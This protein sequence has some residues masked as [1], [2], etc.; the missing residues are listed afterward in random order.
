MRQET[1]SRLFAAIVL[2]FVT[3]TLY[4]TGIDMYAA[5]GV[6]MPDPPVVIVSIF[7]YIGLGLELWKPKTEWKLQRKMLPLAIISIFFAIWTVFTFNILTGRFP[8]GLQNPLDAYFY[9]HVPLHTIFIGTFFFGFF[10]PIYFLFKP[11]ANVIVGGT[12]YNLIGPLVGPIAT[13]MG[14]FRSVY[15][16]DYILEVAGLVMFAYWYIKTPR[17]ERKFLRVNSLLF[18][19]AVSVIVAVVFVAGLLVGLGPPEGSL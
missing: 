6:H 7:L 13:A 8:G 1:V 18:I 4:F 5:K 15:I 10:L 12:I 2:V 11:S 19:V 17:A 14:V 9:E 16:E 3:A